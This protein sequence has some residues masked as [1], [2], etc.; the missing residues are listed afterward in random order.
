[1]IK[2]HQTKLNILHILMDVLLIVAAYL[3]A[4]CLKFKTHLLKED[5]GYL[6]F[7]TYM[8]AMAI[9]VVLLVVLYAL[10]GI[11]RSRRTHGKWYEILNLFRADCIGLAC[12]IA[13]LYIIH[14][15]NFSRMLLAI[16]FVLDMAYEILF[17]VLL[18]SLLRRFRRKGYNQKH[19][20][21][22]GYSRTTK[23][24]IDRVRQYPQWGYQIFGI[25]DDAAHLN[26]SYRGI[27]I[28]GHT[29]ELETFIENNDFD[30]V[31]LTLSLADYAKLENL[32][33]ICEKA[34]VHTKFIPDYNNV[35]QS[36]PYTEDMMGLPIINIR[37][38]PLSNPWNAGVKRLGDVILGT[39]ALVIASPFMGIF[40]LIIKCSS[41]GPVIYSQTRVGYKNR[42]FTMYKFRT[43]KAESEGNRG[44]G[45]VV[46]TKKGDVRVTGFG[47]FLRRTS[48]DELPQLWNVLRGD[49][50]LIGPRPERPYY[51]EIFKDK[52][53]R[54]MV[55]HQ[56]RPGMT[57]WAQVNGYRGNTSI[58][59]RVEYDLY[60]IENWS[61]GFDLRI[62]VHTVLHGFI[63]KN[64]Y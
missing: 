35:F 58:K 39:L 51:V 38:T 27:R 64:A 30:E 43:M 61:V 57:G 23:S 33:A 5:T 10:C 14:E 40:A 18:R 47:R 59:K 56:V 3:S 12:F 24:Y 53:P 9:M 31:I 37:R 60:Y 62:L 21:L 45:D 1:M 50:S 48:L 2:T 41:P 15:D 6:D 17:R 26:A 42:E 29:D 34:G 32:V 7:G 19:V 46:W 52:I 8:A 16:F 44:S 63:N 22:V 54:Y 20:L 25:L 28:L 4:W 11:Y 49:M 36:R 13:G 55:K